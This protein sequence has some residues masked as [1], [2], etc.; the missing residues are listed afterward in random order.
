MIFLNIISEL[1]KEQIQLENKIYRFLNILNIASHPLKREKKANNGL[2]LTISFVAESKILKSFLNTEKNQTIEEI[3]VILGNIL[4][5][6]SGIYF[7]LIFKVIEENNKLASEILVEFNKI[8]HEIKEGS[9]NLVMNE[10]K[11]SAEWC[12]NFFLTNIL[13][14]ADTHALK[15]EKELHSSPVGKL[16]V[17]KAHIYTID[18]YSLLEATI[19]IFVENKLLPVEAFR[20]NKCIFCLTSNGNFKTKEHTL[21]QSLGN[22]YSIL[23][24]G[25]SC[26]ECNK[27]F[28]TIEEKMLGMM[29]FALFKVYFTN[30]TKNGRFPSVKFENVHIFKTRPNKITMKSLV[31]KKGLPKI[32]EQTEN[33]IKLKNPPFSKKTDFITIARVLS[34]AA[35]AGIALE[36]GR[37]YVLD[38]RFNDV[39]N[40]ALHGTPFEGMICVKNTT[41]D[42]INS[43]HMEYIVDE[44]FAQFFYFGLIIIISI[45]SI[46]DIRASEQ[47]KKDFI[48]KNYKSTKNTES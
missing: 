25:W 2:N 4:K 30:F 11:L 39:R 24:R 14:A 8:Y 3:M 29:P 13:E 35:L 38:H 23:P 44:Q 48:V 10:K 6:E 5:E 45:Q 31:G 17:A 22:N 32:I 27:Y 26:D 42:I 33:G 40:F 1:T 7:K 37:D 47:I 9:I 12:F 43:I 46:K 21:P 28:S 34:K 19:K 20:E 18:M 15:V 16:V 41:I 36:K